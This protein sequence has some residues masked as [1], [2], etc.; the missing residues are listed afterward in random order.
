LSNFDR[1]IPNLIY[2]V[3]TPDASLN[4][5]QITFRVGMAAQIKS[6]FLDAILYSQRYEG[7]YNNPEFQIHPESGQLLHFNPEHT[8]QS[9]SRTGLS[10]GILRK[11]WL[12]DARF[13]LKVTKDRFIGKDITNN[14]VNIG[15]GYGSATRLSYEAE[16]GLKAQKETEDWDFVLTPGITIKRVQDAGS[17]SFDKNLP[18]LA[19]S[20]ERSFGWGSTRMSFLVQQSVIVP[21]FNALLMN[22]SH[23]AVGN[24]N[25]RPEKGNS[26]EMSL[27]VNYKFPRGR[28]QLAITPFKRTIQDLIVWQRNSLAK[29]YPDNIA[30]TYAR[31]VEVSLS[32]SLLDDK[33]NAFS[34]Y[35]Y[36]RSTIETPGDINHGNFTPL[37]PLYSGSS[38]INYHSKHWGATLNGRW[39]S[40]R[41]ST[42]SNFDPIS[43][44]GMGLPPYSIYDVEFSYL[45][46]NAK[47]KMTF[48]L[49]IDNILNSEY[50]IVERSPMPGRV[51]F[52]RVIVETI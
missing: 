16:V 18:I 52:L 43:T 33:I 46:S 25:L 32:I 35:I 2:D 45:P 22:E 28:S 5:Q 34:S 48:T 29:Y 38:S 6:N 23:Y 11:M 51:A 9:G 19:G 50:R 17:R 41:Y 31:G 27:E 44:A 37:N 4:S 30:E 21:S 47:T 8:N 10:V 39:V 40:R 26:A 24:R 36:N 14:L 1:G 15:V 7:S 3:P 12:T 49:G 20:V 42:M 13:N